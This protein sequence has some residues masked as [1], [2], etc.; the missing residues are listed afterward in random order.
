MIKQ[1]ILNDFKTELF[2]DEYDIF[3][4]DSREQMLE[5]DELTPEEAAFLEGYENAG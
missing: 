4:A 1:T 5:D 3:N 2:Q